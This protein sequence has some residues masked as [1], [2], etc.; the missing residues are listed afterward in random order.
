[1]HE[2]HPQLDEA[3]TR[4]QDEERNLAATIR[5]L[6]PAGVELRY[7]KG[8]WEI[9]AQVVEH[10]ASRLRVRGPSGKVYWIDVRRVIWP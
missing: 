7:E 5:E 2:M 10:S 1:M 3:L 6:Y 9:P 8:G 4:V